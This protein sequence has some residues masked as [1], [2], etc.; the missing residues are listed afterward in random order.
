MIRKVGVSGN[1]EQ[2]QTYAGIEAT[3]KVVWG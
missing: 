1:I 3:G 2:R